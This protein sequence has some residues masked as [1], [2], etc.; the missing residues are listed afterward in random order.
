[1]TSSRYSAAA[2]IVAA[3]IIL[4]FVG[5][6]A[7]LEYVDSLV[8]ASD[9][10]L[11]TLSGLLVAVFGCQLIIARAVRPLLSEIEARIT[12]GELPDSTRDFIKVGPHVGWIE[13]FILFVFLV[14]GSPPAAALVVTAKTLA[15]APEAKE[16]G[17][18][19]GDYYLIGTLVSV[20]AALVAACLTRL[21]LG[22]P[23]L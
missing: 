23:P 9:R 21:I 12:A 6:K 19:V 10:F 11:I 4:A 15:R 1:M 22:L 13:R 17:K 3:V 20:A 14:A 7:V 8:V 18:L 5:W 16:G 2:G